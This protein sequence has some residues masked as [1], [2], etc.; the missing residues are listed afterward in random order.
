MPNSHSGS[1]SKYCV[2]TVIPEYA[3]PKSK[4]TVTNR[5]LRKSFHGG[6]NRNTSSFLDTTYSTPHILQLQVKAKL[7]HKNF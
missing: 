3:V 2:N 4:S 5:N 6:N 7:C 1:V